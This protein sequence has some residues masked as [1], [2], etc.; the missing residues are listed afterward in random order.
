MRSRFSG[1]IILI[2]GLALASTVRAGENGAA[3]SHAGRIPAAS[4]KSGDAWQ[5][6]LARYLDTAAAD[7]VNRLRYA[8]VTPAHRKALEDHL[9]SQ[10]ALKV[11]ALP[12]KARMAYWINLYNAQTVAVIL[13]AYPVKS[14]L[15]IDLSGSGQSGSGKSGGGEKG[16][17][18]ADLLKVEGRDLSLDAIE[19]AILRPAFKDPRIHFALNCASLGC[20][21]LGPA[22]YTASNVD[23]LMERAAHAFVGSP[24]GAVLQGT[25]LRLS[26]L[27]DWYK[28]DFGRDRKERLEFLARYSPPAQAKAIRE[29]AGKIEYFYDWSLNQAP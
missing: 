11:S 20:P 9:A 24:H 29:H 12:P 16:P 27:F 13:R 15:D 14:I 18:K 28:D 8:S 2:A 7:G 25:T 23:S 17:W 1:I 26:S 22:A 19:N 10:Q 5:V 6:F 4:P 3:G 21:E